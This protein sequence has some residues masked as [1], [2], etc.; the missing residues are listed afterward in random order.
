MGAS[1]DPNE[2]VDFHRADGN[3]T[4]DECGQPYWRHPLSGPLSDL[5]LP[6]LRRL[7]NGELVK[8]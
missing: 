5:G 7:C 2:T 4:C 1:E 3:C 6:F 8:L